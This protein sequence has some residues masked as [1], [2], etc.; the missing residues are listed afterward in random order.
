[1]EDKENKTFP[2][3]EKWMELQRQSLEE[4]RLFHEEYKRHLAT[5]SPEEKEKYIR[6]YIV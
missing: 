5:L 6:K 2:T 1:M 3:H 4:R